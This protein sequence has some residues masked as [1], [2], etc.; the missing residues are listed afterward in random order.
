MKKGLSYKTPEGET[1][2][3]LDFDEINK[4]VYINIIGTKHRWVHESEYCNWVVIDTGQMPKIYTPDI[5]AQ[6]IEEPKVKIK[7]NKKE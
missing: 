6:I 4:M 3:V 7:R 2:K 5:P 1:H